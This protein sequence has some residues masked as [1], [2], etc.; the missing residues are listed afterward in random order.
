MTTEQNATELKPCPFCGDAASI[1][2]VETQN[3]HSVECIDCGASGK[4]YRSKEEAIA[5]WNKRAQ[6]PM[7]RGNVPLSADG[8]SVFIEGFGEVALDYKAGRDAQPTP[9]PAGQVPAIVHD[10]LLRAYSAL[11]SCSIKKNSDFREDQFYFNEVKVR[12][13]MQA[14]KPILDAIPAAPQPER[15][16][17]ANR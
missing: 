7:Q 12:D 9:V 6:Q 15:R 4:V 1:Y 16:N 14:I 3:F 17:D 10:A 8:K 13:A 11:V 2:G 5:A